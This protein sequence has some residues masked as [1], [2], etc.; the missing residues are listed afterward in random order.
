M[1]AATARE[2]ARL[3]GKDGA[4]DGLMPAIVAGNGARAYG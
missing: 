4:A 1:G 2:G 3:K